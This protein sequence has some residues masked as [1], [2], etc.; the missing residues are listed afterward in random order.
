[1]KRTLAFLLTIALLLPLTALAEF[2]L[3]TE[4]I[5]FTVFGQRDQNQAAWKDVYV[6]NEYEK[7]TGVHM[8]W[9]EVPS[10]GFDENKALLF[11]SNE[12]PDLFIRA[13][14]GSNGIL[15]YGVNSQQLIPLN[16]LIE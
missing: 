10:Q 4:N 6:L 11:A 7:M 1:M 5:T 15:E 14:I 16:D 3:T 8:E 2:P 13:F 9:Q 12:L